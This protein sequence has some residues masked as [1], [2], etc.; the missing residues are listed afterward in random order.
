M[1]F[2]AVL[3][4]A[5]IYLY[6]YFQQRNHALRLCHSRCAR[7]LEAVQY[8][9]WSGT[10]HR[11][12]FHSSAFTR[13]FA[14]VNQSKL[15][16]VDARVRAL[17]EAPAPAAPAAAPVPTPP[18]SAAI[19]PMKRE[20]AGP[21][22]ARS[23]SPPILAPLPK[24][25]SGELRFIG[26]HDQFLVAGRSLRGPLTFVT[27]DPGGNCPAAI[28]VGA[29]VGRAHLAEPLPYWPSYE[30][31]TP[32][33]RARYLDWLA[34]G[35]TD[36]TVPIGYV[37]IH[38]YGLEQRALID[39]RDQAAI[40]AELKRLLSIYGENRSFR[41]YAQNLLTFLTLSSIATLDEHQLLEALGSFVPSSSLALMGVLAWFR[42][43]KRP[44][45]APC[46]AFVLGSLE[47]VKRGVVATRSAQELAELFD[48]RYRE[49]FG[50]GLW[51]RAS[52]QEKVP[53]R[54]ASAS[55][56][57]S[58]HEIEIELPHVL[59]QPEQFA[60]V[61]ELWNDCVADLKK[62]SSA[63]RNDEG[64]EM[65]AET[66]AE[67]PSE[68][69]TS[70]EHPAQDAW[71]GLLAGSPRVARYHCVTTGQLLQ[72]T[73]VPPGDSAT[74]AQL[75]Q[76]CEMAALLGY[77]V[78]PDARVNGKKR[79][80]S[81]E[82]VVWRVEDARP[83]EEA[84][85]KSTYAMMSL[86]L[87]VA[88][89]DGEVAASE[90]AI[91][92]SFIEELFVLD[93]S[94]RNRVEALRHLLMRTPAKTTG[95]AKAL[96]TSRS[97]A[98]L[99]KIGRVLVA[100]AGADGIIGDAEHKSLRSLYKGLGL[101]A[102]ELAVAIVAS[103]A[104]LESDA[105][106]SVQEIETGA[107][108]QAI[109]PRAGAPSPALDGKAIAAILAETREVA[110]MLSS[111]LDNEDDAEPEAIEPESAA[112]PVSPAPAATTALDLFGSLDVRYQPIVQQ[113]LTKAS[114]SLS[115][116]KALAASAKLMPGAIIETVNSWSDERLGDYL[117]EEVDGWRIHADLLERARA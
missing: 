89:A 19:A 61:V 21:I 82:V 28:V 113:L 6:F 91:V 77:A 63:K 106:V 60:P 84:L 76:A 59:G 46:A 97:A 115:E 86:L 38:F 51:L 12:D 1:L 58:A 101:S 79:A 108:G 92:A 57:R 95:I 49:K 29:S 4:T 55:L 40:E 53:Y 96:Q 43:R 56:A 10:V 25:S 13:E 35:R 3:F 2:W 112:P 102:R 64:A 67:L 36:A 11:F 99:Q 39:E 48:I 110:A 5:G 117:I 32:D 9:G 66:W 52:K 22:A 114:W 14:I 71:E 7:P 42:L 16:D 70:Y 20:P 62:L 41:G 37:F 27:S 33:Q 104:K 109:P 80:L 50:E 45:P 68:L 24:P 85:W 87:A 107:P 88:A 93:D 75:R 94:M 23:L 54:A 26:A 100:V 72:L 74:A 65:S 105:P 98:E 34:S 90:S 31:A 78:E 47:G 116:V 73:A 17:L 44:L 103:G 18:Q 69:R 15:V 30:S 83:M 111:V 8:L 81:S